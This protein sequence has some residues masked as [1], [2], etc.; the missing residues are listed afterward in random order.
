MELRKKDNYLID[1]NGNKWN[2][3]RFTK[4]QI[5]EYSQTLVNC[6]NCTDCYECENCYDCYECYECENCYECNNCENCEKCNNCEYC[7]NCNNCEDCEECE[8]CQQIVGKCEYDC[9]ESLEEEEDF[10]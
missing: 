1:E 10:E 3:N 7:C 8:S 4:E 6:H 5:F 2:L 9:N